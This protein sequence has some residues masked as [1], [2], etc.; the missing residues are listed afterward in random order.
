MLPLTILVASKI[1]G[2]SSYTCSD[3]CVIP[4][5]YIS[6]GWCDCCDCEDEVSYDCYSCQCPSDCG[7][8]NSCSSTSSGYGPQCGNTETTTDEP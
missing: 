2:A 4:D 6:D 7:D 8:Y 1:M 5:S 3:G